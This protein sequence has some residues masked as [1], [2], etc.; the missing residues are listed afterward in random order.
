MAVKAK[1][2]GKN[3]CAKKTNRNMLLPDVALFKDKQVFKKPLWSP[4]AEQKKNSVY[5]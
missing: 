1:R 3:H 5:I 4:P 2:G